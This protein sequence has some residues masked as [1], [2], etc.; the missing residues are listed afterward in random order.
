MTKKS[1]RKLQ[2]RLKRARRVNA[3]AQKKAKRAVAAYKK[4]LKAYKAA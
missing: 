1:H 2:L 3:Q 4:V